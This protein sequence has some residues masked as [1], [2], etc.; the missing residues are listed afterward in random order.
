MA[1]CELS[2][3]FI[4]SVLNHK[5]PAVGIR[6]HSNLCGAS[7]QL[8]FIHSCVY[9]SSILRQAEYYI[10]RGSSALSSDNILGVHTIHGTLDLYHTPE[11]TS[12]RT[13]KL[14][15]PFSNSLP[16][17][18]NFLRNGQCICHGS[19]HGSVGVYCIQDGDC[20]QMIS[21]HCKIYMHVFHACMLIWFSRVNCSNGSM[22]FLS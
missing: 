20:F 7:N 1:S 11:V 8:R 17:P 12:F 22:S 18:A 9:Q 5:I 4:R 10:N 21:H 19:E 3:L 6:V 16:L 14:S 13:I 2:S 15:R